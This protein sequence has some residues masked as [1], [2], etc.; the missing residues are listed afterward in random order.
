MSRLIYISGP[1][2]SFNNHPYERQR[3][4]HRN[5]QAIRHVCMQIVIH[6][7]EW[8]P[9][10]P[11]CTFYE[12]LFD[13]TYKPGLLPNTLELLTRCD[14]MIVLPGWEIDAQCSKEI[15][16]MRQL[17]KPIFNNVSEITK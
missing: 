1:V 11:Q 10:A 7:S 5:I 16:L 12:F 4:V 17:N 6:R 15:R 13:K 8:L 14:A 9:V 3:E 2:D